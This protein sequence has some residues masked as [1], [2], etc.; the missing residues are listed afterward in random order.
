MQLIVSEVGI[1]SLLTALN[2][3]KYFTRRLEVSE[4]TSKCL[5]AK[6]LSIVFWIN[7]GAFVKSIEAVSNNET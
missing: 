3:A 6:E 1:F 7:C 5:L 2:L 4:V